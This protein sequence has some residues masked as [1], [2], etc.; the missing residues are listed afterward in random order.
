M[1]VPV[2]VKDEFKKFYRAVFAH[3]YRKEARRAVFTEYAWD[4]SWCD[5]CADTPLSQD[6]LRGL[7]VF[8]DGATPLVTRLHVRYDKDH[9]PEDLVFQET[10]N[11]ENFQARYV[12]QHEFKG[13]LECEAGQ[14]YLKTLDARREKEADTLASLTGWKKPDIYRHMGDEAPKQVAEPW[15][16]RLW[17]D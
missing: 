2:Y 17:K 8:W 4:S 11:R 13:P 6:E 12:L 5:P 3:S 1:D 10:G 14:A 9:F 16:K 15:Y 7:G